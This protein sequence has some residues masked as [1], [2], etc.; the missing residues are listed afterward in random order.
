MI[1][2]TNITLRELAKPITDII[3]PFLSALVPNFESQLIFIISFA[4]AY[5]TKAKNKWNYISFIGFGLI[6][7][8]FLMYIGLGNLIN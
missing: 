4:I 7:Y 6:L 2:L 1:D 5:A 3:N 8:G